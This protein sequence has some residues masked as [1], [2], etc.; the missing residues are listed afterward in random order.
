MMIL[1]GK[2]TGREIKPNQDGTA[3][4]L[5]LQVEVTDPDDVRTIEAV[6]Q[7]GDDTNPPNGARVVI[8]SITDN[9]QVAIGAD[10]GIEPTMDAG[11]KKLYSV[12]S[13]AIAAYINLLAN[14]DIELNGN[15]NTAVAF[16]ALASGFNQLVTDF[17]THVHSGVTS[18]GA[19]TL[20][21]TSTS[22][23]DISAAEVTEVKLP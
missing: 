9:Y 13:G 17:N 19:S 18:G 5:L 21:P 7:A 12:S 14:G 10:D 22:S 8:L 4:K 23:A 16:A 11:E 1:S 20:I 15:A 3:N 6:T 2:V